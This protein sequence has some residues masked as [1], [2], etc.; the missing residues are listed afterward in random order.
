M[1]KGIILL[2]SVMIMLS[3]FFIPVKAEESNQYNGMDERNQLITVDYETPTVTG[4]RHWT[5]EYNDNWFCNDA[6]VYNH[7]LARMSLGLTFASF[8]DLNVEES[9]EEGSLY[10]LFRDAGFSNVRENDYDH[11]TNQYTVSTG[12]A[13]KQITDKNGETFTLI[14]IGICGHGYGAEWMSNCTIGTG[15]QHEGFTKAAEVVYDRIFGYIA[16]NHISGRI[17]YWISGFSRAAAISNMVAKMLDDSDIFDERDGF[18][19]TFATPRNTRDPQKDKYQNIFN[20]VGKNDPVPQVP[21]ADWGY[22]R[23]GVSLYTPS[24]QSD[25]NFAAL[26]KSANTIFY[27]AVGVEMWNNVEWDTK[28]RVILNYCLKLMPTPEA[29]VAL[30]QEQLVSIIGNPSVPNIIEQFSQISK[31]AAVFE[32]SEKDELENFLNYLAYTVYSYATNTDVDSEYR[33]AEASLAS[34]LAHEHVYDVYLAWMY[35][36]DDPEQLFSQH[37]DYMRLQVEGEADVALI[38]MNPDSP[39]LIGGIMSD[40][41][42][43]TSFSIPGAYYFLLPSTIDIFMGRTGNETIIHLPKDSTYQVLIRSKKPQDVSVHVQELTVGY[44][45]TEYSYMMTKHQEVG[46]TISIYSW[47]TDDDFNEF[48]DFWIVDHDTFEPVEIIYNSDQQLII[49]AQRNSIINLSWKQMIVLTYTLP[50]IIATLL[51]Y[52]MAWAL[53]SLSTRRKIRLERLA[54]DT[55]YEKLTAFSLITCTSLYLVQELYYWMI[56][57]EKGVRTI[58]KAVIGILMLVVAYTGYKKRKTE[59]SL[60]ITIAI[61]VM[62]VADLTINYSFRLGTIIYAIA[63]IILCVGCYRFNKPENWQYALWFVL[64]TIAIAAVS[65]YFGAAL[66][67]F[68][69]AVYIYVLVLTA[70][71]L[72]SLQQPR[73]IRTGIM[74]LILG[75]LIMLIDVTNSVVLLTH[76]VALGIHYT[77]VSTLARS[78]RFK[79][80]PTIYQNTQPTVEAAPTVQ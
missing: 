46:D 75:D 40:G 80:K 57:E 77:A 79:L 33:S 25:S 20:I 52:L 18:A 9:F 62:M 43:M 71:L 4:K 23:Y 76:I 56:P 13:S 38:S 72:L 50:I 61:G 63:A 54:P 7:K 60:F 3:A 64:A 55:K 49:D 59:L 14:A 32:G 27:N 24:Q 36:T 68:A 35:A 2:C 66:G 26:F 19:Y 44:T 74:L 30:M 65:H 6:R 58:M 8:R 39:G 10:K 51:A 34:N 5:F 78:T 47:W 11:A 22:D 29:Y 12:I 28:L 70:L 48:D 45:N 15:L 67:N 42:K 69:L 53:G 21:F 37:M 73:R 17:K 16:T 41:S 1:K 31:N